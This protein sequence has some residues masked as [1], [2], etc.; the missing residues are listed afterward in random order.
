MT[1]THPKIH[2]PESHDD[3]RLLRVYVY[4]R[5]VLAILLVSLFTVS[6]ALP[7]LGAN[8]PKLFDL[9]Y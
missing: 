3:W 6:P 9:Q 1:T 4:Y 2:F 8:N 5:L 7:L